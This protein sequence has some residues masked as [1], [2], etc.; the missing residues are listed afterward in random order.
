M[1]QYSPGGGNPRPCPPHLHLTTHL[2]HR[3]HHAPLPQPLHPPATNP[4]PQTIT[5][6]IPPPSSDGNKETEFGPAGYR[7]YDFAPH[8]WY[9]GALWREFETFRK[10]P[11]C[12]E[13]EALR[14]FTRSQTLEPCDRAH[15][16]VSEAKQDDSHHA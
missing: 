5:F 14:H 12:R 9:E 10:S 3:C 1:F 8:F 6:S 2:P 7:A 16:Y 15:L 11:L 13:S 4:T